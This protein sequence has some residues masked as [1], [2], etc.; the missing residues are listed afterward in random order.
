[1]VV[2]NL[3]CLESEVI[4]DNAK[5]IKETFKMSSSWP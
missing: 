4:D 5:E 3:S 1:M 2:D